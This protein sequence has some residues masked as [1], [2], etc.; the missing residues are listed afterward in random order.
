[1]A[2]QPAGTNAMPGMQLAASHGDH[3]AAATRTSCHDQDG[4]P[5]SISH[6][7]ETG[8]ISESDVIPEAGAVDLHEAAR[9]LES[10]EHDVKVALSCIGLGN[11]DRAHEHAITA[12]AATDAAETLIRAALATGATIPG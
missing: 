3:R 4:E 7:P 5:V 10:A 1:M 8:A 6:S 11:L 9:Q 12:R 2:E